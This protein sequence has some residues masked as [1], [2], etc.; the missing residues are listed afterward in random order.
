[1]E[2]LFVN[3]RSFDLTFSR[4]AYY[5]NVH[6]LYFHDLLTTTNTKEIFNQ[7]FFVVLEKYFLATT[8]TVMLSTGANLQPYTSV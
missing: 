2:Y 3:R 7:Y 8:W 5:E 1:M 6:A 4:T